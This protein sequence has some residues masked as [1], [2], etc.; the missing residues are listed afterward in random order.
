MPLVAATCSL[1]ACAK[2]RQRSRVTV[3]PSTGLTFCGFSQ[4]H[5]SSG[6]VASRRRKVGGTDGFALVLWSICALSAQLNK[7]TR[8][9]RVFTAAAFER[10]P[11]GC[12]R[13]EFPF[14]RCVGPWTVRGDASGSVPSYPREPPP[15]VRAAEPQGPWRA[16]II[17]PT[18]P[19]HLVGLSRGTVGAIRG[20]RVSGVAGGWA[21]V[22]KLLGLFA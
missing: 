1:C 6:W 11:A 18:A 16:E 4:I 10:L 20:R 3:M 8:L 7:T 14:H 22:W 13:Q 9:R 5:P 12:K 2:R 17:F 19:R 15:N 21:K